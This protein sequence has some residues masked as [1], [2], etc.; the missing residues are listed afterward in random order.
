[1][2]RLYLCKCSSLQLTNEQASSGRKACT[3]Y[4]NH[5]EDLPSTVRTIH[6]NRYE[7]Q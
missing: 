6:Q 5:H 2:Q 3:S 4:Y 7:N 1:M